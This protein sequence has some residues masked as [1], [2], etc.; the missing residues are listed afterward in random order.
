M[1]LNVSDLSVTFQTRGAP[2]RVLENIYFEIKAGE[3]VAFAGESGCGKTTLAKTILKILPAEARVSGTIQFEESDI[4]KLN[5]RE[6]NRLRGRDIAYIPQEPALALNPVLP[7]GAQVE[8]TLIIHGLASGA[9]ARRRAL[10]SMAA[11]GLQN[12]QAIYR[13][14]AHRLSGGM[15]QRVAIAAAMAA[16]PKL[17]IADE[18]TTALDATLKLQIFDYFEQAR[19]SWNASILYISHDLRA[20][21]RV[22]SKIYI[23]YAGRIVESGST[24]EILQNPLHPY[25]KAL[26]NCASNITEAIP[27]SAPSPQAK[28][29][30]CAY[31]PR[32]PLALEKCKLQIPPTRDF[33]LSKRSAACHV[34]Q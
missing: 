33:D 21:S 31:H 19:R 5:D 16:R 20:L 23:L 11:V 32:C 8:E 29:A 2:A 17:L 30:G 3:S 7:V 24:A 9:E 34:I 25:T 6:M 26:L 15:R 14:A 13:E 22:A 18:A 28:P 1:L 4:C 12:A 10:E 27:G